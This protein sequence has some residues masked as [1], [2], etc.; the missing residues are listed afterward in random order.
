ME[1]PI[2]QWSLAAICL[3][4]GLALVTQFRTY[5]VVAKAGLSPADQAVVINGLVDSNAALRREIGELEGKLE[6]LTQPDSAPGVGAME[7]E[8]AQ[9]K[10]ATGAAPVSGPGVEVF[11]GAYVRSDELGDLV[12]ELR[13]AGA[14]AVAVNG[15]RLGARS[16][17]T[18][19]P[20]GYQVDGHE[21]TAPFRFSAIGV[22]AIL[23]TALSRK[24]GLV[25]LMRN[26]Y[27]NQTIETARRE[28]LALP[29]NQDWSVGYQVARPEP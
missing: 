28:R 14:E 29:A 3:L 10:I 21:I 15:W 26:D 17:F 22:P 25:S 16:V 12:N 6:A 19:G 8:L 27:P 1:R 23:E 11:V 9:L 24:G 13:N 7:K 5:H 20:S 2:A 4:L 18:L